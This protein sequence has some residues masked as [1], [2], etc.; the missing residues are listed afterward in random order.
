MPDRQAQAVDAILRALPKGPEWEYRKVTLEKAATELNPGERSDV[1][2]I[3]TEAPDRAKEVVLAKGMNDAQF[4]LNPIVTV[5]HSYWSQPA[6]KS[7]WRKRVKDGDRV[8]IKAKTRYPDKPEDWPENEHGEKSPWLPDRVFKLV[9][10]GALNGKSIGFLPLKGHTPDDREYQRNG[11]KHDQVRYVYDE[12]LLLE[13]AV[14]YMPCNGEALVEEVSKGDVP[15]T[16]LQALGVDPATVR[17]GPMIPPPAPA[18]KT[19]VPFT[20]LREVE[21]AVQSA[22]DRIDLKELA[23][24]ATEE[25]YQRARG[26]V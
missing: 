6:G 11:W 22:I 20:T 4:A 17:K 9:Q 25:A 3:S 7:L 14:C 26:R 8:G 5:A 10:S 21:K 19:I 15:D 23:R 18:P 16:L 24:K 13:Y 2:W 12:W 1:S